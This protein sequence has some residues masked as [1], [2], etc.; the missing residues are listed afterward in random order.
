ML[1]S[2]ENFRFH[3]RLMLHFQFL[4]TIIAKDD[5]VVDAADVLVY[6]ICQRPW[7]TPRM[8]RFALERIITHYAEHPVS[9]CF[10]TVETV[11]V[12]HDQENHQRCA[13]TDGKPQDIDQGEDL[14]APKVPQRDDR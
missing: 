8:T 10:E 11:L 3:G 6:G 13:D 14:V 7:H 4:R 9:L 1:L 12:L 2:F 5:D